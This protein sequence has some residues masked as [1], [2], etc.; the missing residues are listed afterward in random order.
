M[1]HGFA[2]KQDKNH[3]EIVMAFRK[4]GYSVLDLKNLAGGA[5]DIAV[6]HGPRFIGLF[7]IKTET[8]KLNERQMKWREEWTGPKPAIIRSI[9]E[10]LQISTLRRSEKWTK[11]TT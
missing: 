7:E 10:V 2:R 4:C 5:P 3:T 6:F 1:K 11:R 8:G 9:D